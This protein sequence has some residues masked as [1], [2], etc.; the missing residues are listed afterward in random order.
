MKVKN[1]E[2]DLEI[3]GMILEKVPYEEICKKYNL[4]RSSIY[5][6]L[7]KFRKSKPRPTYSVNNNYFKEIDTPEKAYWLGWLASDGTIN[8]ETNIISICLQ[9][10]DS[11]ILKKLLSYIESSHPLKFHAKQSERHQNKIGFYISSKKLRE[12][13][14]NFGIVP[15][16]TLITCVPNIEKSLLKYFIRGYFD[17]DGCISFSEKR[18]T[19]L[20]SISSA[21]KTV[22]EQMKQIIFEEIGINV[23]IFFS[24]KR[25]DHYLN[26]YK[27]QKQGSVDVLKLFEWLY[28]GQEHLSLKRKYEKFIYVKHYFENKKINPPKRKERTGTKIGQFSSDGKTLIKEWESSMQAARAMKKDN[29]HILRSSKKNSKAYGFVWKTLY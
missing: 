28:T 1:K 29:T 18:K 15:N 2:R 4:K 8:N 17:G 9:E 21:S 6:V 24:E 20:F 13:L 26:A 10:R 3:Y 22:Q 19:L 12:Q 14:V 11:E 25:K 5:R 7:R 16:K 27:L 23:N